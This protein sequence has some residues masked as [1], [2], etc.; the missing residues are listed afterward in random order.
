[1]DWDGPLFL[2]RDDASGVTV[3]STEPL[4]L[5]DDVEA[6]RF[7]INPLAFSDELGID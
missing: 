3:P 4:L 6:L 5:A 2:Q 7:H 1:M